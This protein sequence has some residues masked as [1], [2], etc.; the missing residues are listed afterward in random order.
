M[1]FSVVLFCII[2]AGMLYKKHVRASGMSFILHVPDVGQGTCQVVELPGGRLMVMD[3]GGFRSSTFDTGERIVAPF[4][5]TLGYTH[6]DIL[7]L[8]HPETDHVGGLPALVRQFSPDELWTNSDTAPW[9]PAWNNLVD[10]ARETGVRHVIFREDAVFHRFGVHFQ[11]FTS[12]ECLSARSRNSRSLVIRLSHEGGTFLLTGDIDRQREACLV[13][14]GPGEADVVVVPHHGSRTSSSPDFISCVHPRAAFISAGW[15]N[16]LGLPAP[17]VVD[18][19]R[20]AGAEVLSTA[21]DGTL[22][23]SFRQGGVVLETYSGDL[24]NHY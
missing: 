10:A 8:S 2:P 13:A 12:S 4:V 5:R 19:W 21:R 18:R 7:A 14:Q 15:R 16:Y 3:G 9:N 24:L 23:A 17:D 22:T 1:I 6:I 20:R 11:V